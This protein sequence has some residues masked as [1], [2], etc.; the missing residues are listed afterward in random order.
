MA[1]YSGKPLVQKL[2][3]KPGFCIFVDGLSVGY[4]AI[5]G[6]LPDGVRMMRVAKAPLD[7]V[8]LFAT[9]A[10]GLGARLRSYRKAIAPD[11]MIWVS[12]PKKASGVATDVTET[13]VRATALTNGLVDIKVCAVD[14]VW[15][16]LKLV[17]PVKERGKLA[18]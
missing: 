15:S 10:K 5:V 9:E 8:H 13:V 14:D 12:W 18:K 4:G 17:I 3:I 6:D 11:G 1:G 16:G 7:L 2:G